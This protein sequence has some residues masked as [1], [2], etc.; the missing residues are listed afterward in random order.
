ME[1][2]NITVNRHLNQLYPFMGVK[3]SEPQEQIRGLVE[4]GAGGTLVS[5]TA[6]QLGATQDEFAD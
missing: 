3:K 5:K 2:R 1:G 6:T 4:D